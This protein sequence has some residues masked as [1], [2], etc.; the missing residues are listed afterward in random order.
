MIIPMLLI[1]SVIAFALSN[2]SAGDVAEITI[3][4]EGGIVTPETLAQ[5]RQ[6]LGLDQPLILQYLNWLGNAVQFDFGNS[7]S[8][9]KPVMQEIL[10]RFPATLLLAVTATVMAFVIAVPI[11]LVSAKYQGG[12]LDHGLRVVTTA[13]ATMPNF[14]LGL[15]LL[16]AFAIHLGIV[17]V[18]AGNHFANVFL[19]AF[20]MCLGDAAVYIRMIRSN[21]IE[22]MRSDYVK[23]AKAKG[24]G[25]N[26]VLIK[27]GLKNAVLPCFTLIATNF[28][29]LLTGSFAVETIFSWNGI[30]KYAVE[31]VKA[32]DFPVIQGY[33][34]AAALAYVF[35]NLIVDIVY[36]YIDPKIKL[37]RRYRR[38]VKA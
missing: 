17:P 16:Y 28:G 1:V 3:R 35:V 32:K 25:E 21:L 38:W 34:I 30:G 27:H 36:F 9:G 7:F 6:E 15:L 22:V 18:I 20:T 11:A 33:I 14:W 2:L 12:V 31:S 24:M 13:G 19:P 37:E 4:N 8:S 26:M 10:S 29:G 5:V 23:A